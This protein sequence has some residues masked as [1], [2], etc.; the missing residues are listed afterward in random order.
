MGN[1]KEGRT[2][3][4]LKPSR[5][6]LNSCG[7]ISSIQDMWQHKVSSQGLLQ[8]YPYGLAYCRLCSLS[9]VLALLMAYS[10][11]WQMFPVPGI[12]NF[13]GS[14]LGLWLHPH[15]LTHCPLRVFCMNSDPAICCLEFQAFL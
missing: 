8:P 6:N 2:K 15:S 10:F 11:Q 1:R 13:L 7:S 5:E 3:T 14:P 4:T 12:S 9:P